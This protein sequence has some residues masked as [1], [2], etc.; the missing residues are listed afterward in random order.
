MT[1]DQ[2]TTILL[3]VKL[4]IQRTFHPSYPGVT[5]DT[6]QQLTRTV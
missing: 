5:Q 1:N 6:Q 4:L 3:K 2:M